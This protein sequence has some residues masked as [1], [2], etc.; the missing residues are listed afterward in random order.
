[1]FVEGAVREIFDRID[2]ELDAEDTAR[3]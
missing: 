1:V 2:Q 3:P